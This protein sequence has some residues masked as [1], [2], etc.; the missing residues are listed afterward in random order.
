[1]HRYVIY[2]KIV[3]FLMKKRGKLQLHFAHLKNTSRTHIASFNQN[4]FASAHRNLRPHI[5]NSQ[6]EIANRKSSFGTN[7]FTQKPLVDRLFTCL[8]GL[9]SIMWFS[10]LHLVESHS[11]LL[12][13]FQKSSKDHIFSKLVFLP[14]LGILCIKKD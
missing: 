8:V 6:L 3:Y 11:L 12:G 10:P 4:G 1:M 9:K 5:C 2:I 13:H 14:K 7:L